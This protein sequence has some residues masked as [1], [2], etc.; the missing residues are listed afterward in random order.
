MFGVLSQAIP[1]DAQ[2]RPAP[3]RP[4]LIG[5]PL[6]AGSSSEW[7]KRQ[8]VTLLTRY[9][10]RSM[11]AGEGSKRRSVSGR[12]LGPKKGVHPI[13]AVIATERTTTRITTVIKTRF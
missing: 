9:S 8:P 10:P 4:G 1:S 7:Q 3:A 13:V 12:V 6:V 11:R 2:L 5:R